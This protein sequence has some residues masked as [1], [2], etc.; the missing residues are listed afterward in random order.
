MNMTK[1]HGGAPKLRFAAW[2]LGLAVAGCSSD[3]AGSGSLSVLLDVEDSIS[4]GLMP[5]DDVENIQDGWAAK[6]GKFIVVIGDIDLH[7]STDEHVEAEAP[8]SFVTDLKKVPSSGLALWKV[9]DLREGRWEFNFATPGA[10]HGAKRHDSVSQTDYDA[11]VEHDWTY[12]I[13]GSLSKASGQSC[14]P[15]ALAKPGGKEDNGKKSG[16]NACYDASEVRFTFGATVETRFGPCEIDEMPG[17][18]IVADST[19]TVA[20]TIHG[21][22]LFFNGF[23]EGDEGGVMRLA[24]WL[25]DCDLDLDGTV[26]EAELK[27][28]T[29]AQ[30]PELD[31]RYQLGGSP[32]ALDNMHK[33]AISQLKTQGHFQGEGECQVDGVAHDHGH[34]HD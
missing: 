25:A 27:A 2:I 7:L 4:N 32:I 17:V 13:D 18:A 26:T 33:Y 3:E 9:D 23:P 15:A 20:V 29:P 22:H 6:Y 24:Q 34:D 28:I 31:E 5:G 21:D 14:P 12:F 8:E 10:A 16:G 30:L 11:M 1:P 19:Q